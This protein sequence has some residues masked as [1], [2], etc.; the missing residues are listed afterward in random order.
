MSIQRACIM[1]VSLE[2]QARVSCFNERTS[3]E[4]CCAFCK[5]LATRSNTRRVTTGFYLKTEWLLSIGAWHAF[6]WMIKESFSEIYHTFIYSAST[7]GWVDGGHT[8]TTELPTKKNRL[9]EK[10]ISLNLRADGKKGSCSCLH[11]QKSDFL[12]FEIEIC[13]KCVKI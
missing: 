11:A 2:Y 9:P 6:I 8:K 10:E 12:F 5:L 1:H 3:R 4:V 7:Q 13:D